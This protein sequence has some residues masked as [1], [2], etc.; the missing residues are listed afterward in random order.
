MLSLV[1]FAIGACV[2]SFV[3]VVV[4]RFRVLPIAKARSKCL[5]CNT[6]IEKRDLIPIFSF[7]LLRG[8]CRNCGGKFSSEYM[9]VEIF[10][11]VMAVMIWQIAIMSPAVVSSVS[12]VLA[13]SQ[14]APMTT[15][16]V[17]ASAGVAAEGVIVYWKVI[18]MFVYYLAIFAL[19][20]V[21]A[22]YDLRHKVVPMEFS[23]VLIVMGILASLYRVLV[24]GDS[25][26][27]LVAGV[28]VAL[29]FGLIFAISKGRWVGFG[30]VMVYAGV[31]WALGLAMGATILFY[32]VWIGAVVAILLMMTESKSYGL[33]T[34][35]PF[36]PFIVI[37]AIIV[38][39]TKADILGIND[40]LSK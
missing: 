27:N 35:L 33:K 30:D 11:G 29:P 22:L 31:G 25:Y 19:L 5:T 7:L 26:I 13:A 17:G 8:R 9:W 14:Y 12:E 21:I 15:M 24:M 36:A 32:S 1:I 37:A 39:L 34:E 2:G 6:Q 23:G 38:F 28:L 10:M 16:T 4:A 20:A 40:L 18:A 3:N